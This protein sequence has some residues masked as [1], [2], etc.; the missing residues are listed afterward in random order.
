MRPNQFYRYVAGRSLR[1]II[2]VSLKTLI[3]FIR[4]LLP[5]ERRAQSQ[6]AA[7]DRLWGTDTTKSVKRRD[8]DFPTGQEKHFH[9]Y[10]VSE[11]DT[12]K[13]LLELLD[14]DPSKFTFIDI[15]S[16]KGRVVFEASQIP[17]QRSIG[18]EYSRKLHDIAQINA[19]L[20]T[21][22]GGPLVKPEFWQGDARDFLLPEGPLLLY[23]YNPFSSAILDE[24]INRIEQAATDEARTIY[25]AYVNPEHLDSLK[26][27]SLW[28]QIAESSKMVIFKLSS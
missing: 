12:L 17:F 11:H 5:S 10:E 7:F 6:L 15:G 18:V 2:A 26:S 4:G 22:R 16:G 1:E 19:R 3:G 9:Q 21:E 14:I 20:F 8:L 13:G 23:L 25:L 24:F 27:R 28:M